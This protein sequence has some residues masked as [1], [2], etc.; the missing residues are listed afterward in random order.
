M[1]N[2]PAQNRRPS[3]P[4]VSKLLAEHADLGLYRAPRTG[5]VGFTVKN[6]AI[7]KQQDRHGG[8][9][10][11]WWNQT[12]RA[13]ESAKLISHAR[14][15]LIRQLLEK[16]GFA[17][18]VH[19]QG[20][21]VVLAPEDVDAHHEAQHAA[22]VLLGDATAFRRK[23]SGALLDE[24]PVLAVARARAVAEVALA[25]RTGQCPY[26]QGGGV[27][28][29]G[30]ITVRFEPV[31][32]AETGP[33]HSEHPFTEARRIFAQAG[34]TVLDT[35]QAATLTGVWVR[36]S[37]VPGEVLVQRKD[38]GRHTPGFTAQARR[39]TTLME[40][41]RRLME[42][43]GWRM[44][45]RGEMGWS[46]HRPT[47]DDALTRAD[48]VLGA[49]WPQ[50]R[51]GER[52]G[53]AFGRREGHHW[54]VEWRSE[55][56]DEER[57]AV[58]EVA[59]LPYLADALRRVGLSTTMP[60]ELPHLP[61]DRP[62]SPAVYFAAPPAE[63]ARP[64]YRAWEHLGMW[65]VDDTHTGFLRRK[66][67]D[68]PHAEHLAAIDNREEAIFRR[69]GD[70]DTL[71]GMTSDLSEVPEFRAVAAELAAAG[72]LPAHRWEGGE[73][74][75]DG[76]MLCLVDKGLQVNH[77][78]TDPSGSVRITRPE[79]SAAAVVFDG[80][81]KGYWFALDAPGRIVTMQ[82]DHLMVYGAEVPRQESTEAVPDGEQLFDAAVTFRVDHGAPRTEVYRLS[83]RRV[84][85]HGDGTV[86]R[87][88]V[89][90]SIGLAGI[91]RYVIDRVH[92]FEPIGTEK[93][94]AQMAATRLMARALGPRAVWCVEVD[95]LGPLKP[96]V[97]PAPEWEGVLLLS[98]PDDAPAES[99]PR[100][101]EAAAESGWS[102]ARIASCVLWVNV[103]RDGGDAH[104]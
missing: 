95:P 11:V 14:H 38:D 10:I 29:D 4:A 61:G 44:T 53:W 71:P 93:H 82:G 55:L 2:V 62:K 96:G 49:L 97:Q 45:G 41:Y 80:A 31:T 22:G 100:V 74:P 27:A 42:D 13:P 67:C 77:L 83:S 39:W 87:H 56:A 91:D 85:P 32:D 3:A 12:D 92:A 51:A 99:I 76:F 60:D 47:R 28:I 68:E 37:P 25:L 5:A 102:P 103:P 23:E 94:R 90:E 79:D 34:E 35:K 59:M 6:V 81:L 86:L 84:D 21:L 16:A 46:F 58:A 66:A 8:P 50:H 18:A 52:S 40:F 70:G 64:R 48:A 57:R 17:V 26:E 65:W 88:K 98:V 15:T 7:S 69:T 78:I 24:P 19:H 104:E 89:A 20:H 75:E 1:P 30:Y 54:H 43:A 33:A 72:Y 9:V 36:E 73:R 63:R 101:Q